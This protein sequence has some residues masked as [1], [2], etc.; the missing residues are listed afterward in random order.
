[1]D[2]IAFNYEGWARKVKKRNF[3]LFLW[4][5]KFITHTNIQIHVTGSIFIVN[6][7]FLNAPN[8]DLHQRTIYS[9]YWITKKDLFTTERSPPPNNGNHVCTS[10]TLWRTGTAMHYPNWVGIDIYVRLVYN[11][12]E[13]LLCTCPRNFPQGCSKQV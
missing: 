10:Y 11:G 2:E 5:Q 7:F 4:A 3:L 9:I 1:M 13:K 6:W 12:R 8:N